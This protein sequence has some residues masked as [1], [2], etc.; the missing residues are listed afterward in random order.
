M[1]VAKKATGVDRVFDLISKIWKMVLIVA[2]IG[3]A[4]VSISRTWDKIDKNEK[5]WKAIDDKYNALIKEM[6][7]DNKIQLDDQHDLIIKNIQ[8][9]SELKE[10]MNDHEISAA[11]FRGRVKA[12]LKIQ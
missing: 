11:E 12:I 2:I 9:V 8:R 10:R 6:I 3:T 7:K 5:E 1:A 4:F